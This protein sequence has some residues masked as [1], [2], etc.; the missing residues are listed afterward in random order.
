MGQR[1]G[2]RGWQAGQSVER[3]VATF[4]DRDGHR[5]KSDGDRIETAVLVD[6]ALS[7]N[8][9]LVMHYASPSPAIH[10]P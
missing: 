9:D 3:L 8:D 5:A 1:R 7:Y 10:M 4:S 6:T 2:R